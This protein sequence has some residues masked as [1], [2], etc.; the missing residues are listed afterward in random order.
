MG[1]VSGIG[2]H[3]PIKP[4][5][6]NISNPFEDTSK[7]IKDSSKVVFMQ[8]NEDAKETPAKHTYTSDGQHEDVLGRLRQTGS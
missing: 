6:Q 2:R 3:D 8:K 1:D 5:G 7:K 4:T